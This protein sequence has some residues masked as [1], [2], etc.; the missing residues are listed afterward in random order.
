MNLKFIRNIS[1]V[2]LILTIL[3]VLIHVW[4]WALFGIS[5]EISLAIHVTALISFFISFGLI[6]FYDINRD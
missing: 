6:A 4:W 2:L 3:L 1:V 5:K